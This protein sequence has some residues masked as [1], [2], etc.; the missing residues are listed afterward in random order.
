MMDFGFQND[1]V[2]YSNYLKN[3][4]NRSWDMI[5]GYCN[6]KYRDTHGKASQYDEL[7]RDLWNHAPAKKA[8]DE[9]RGEMSFMQ[10]I[11]LVCKEPMIPDLRWF[12]KL[13]DQYLDCPSDQKAIPISLKVWHA[14]RELS[15]LRDF[16][17]ATG[18][19]FD[20]LN[21]KGKVVKPA[22]RKGRTSSLT[23]LSPFVY[24]MRILYQ[25][26]CNVIHPV[27]PDF[28]LRPRELVLL[29]IACLALFELLTLLNQI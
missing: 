12:S 1:T 21:A 10:L 13:W 6:F 23:D 28:F 25:M 27:R 29:N 3:L 18:Y 2:E 19:L 8:L 16:S 15:K 14:Y 17:L 24:A 20:T 5:E 22:D 26:R 7:G 9:N 4:F 11:E